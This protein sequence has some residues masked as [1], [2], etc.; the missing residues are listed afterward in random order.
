M[1]KL[2]GTSFN[3]RLWSYTPE[4]EINLGAIKKEKKVEKA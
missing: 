3:P 4:L 2:C 1:Q